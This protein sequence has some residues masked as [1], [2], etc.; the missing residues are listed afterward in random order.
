MWLGVVAWG[1]GTPPPPCTVILSTTFSLVLISVTGHFKHKEPSN[2]GHLF[3][4]HSLFYITYR[5]ASTSHAMVANPKVSGRLA[6]KSGKF[7][8]R[9][10]AWQRQQEPER[11]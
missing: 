11:G 7:D 10:P 5:T 6:T 4:W 9:V 8:V 1:V 3:E 2:E